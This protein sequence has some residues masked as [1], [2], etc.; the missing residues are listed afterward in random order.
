MPRAA[1]NKSKKK[2]QA[3]SFSGD[4]TPPAFLR[5]ALKIDEDDF[6]DKRVKNEKTQSLID[7][8]FLGC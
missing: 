1:I 3:G 8:F 7:I 6:P 5:Q 2:V 4:H